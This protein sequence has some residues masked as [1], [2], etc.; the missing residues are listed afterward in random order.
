MSLVE[1]SLTLLIQALQEFARD[2]ACYFPTSKTG[3]VLETSLCYKPTTTAIT[4][5]GLSAAGGRITR[6]ICRAVLEGFLEYDN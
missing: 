4:R 2:H 6:G 5:L 3:I 1:K